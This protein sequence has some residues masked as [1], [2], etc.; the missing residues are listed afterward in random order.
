MP[1]AGS[2]RMN[3]YYFKIGAGMQDMIEIKE[4]K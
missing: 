3:V 1:L 2:T 4:G